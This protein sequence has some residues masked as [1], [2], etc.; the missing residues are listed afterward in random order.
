LPLQDSII[1]SQDFTAAGDSQEAGMKS[2][3][4]LSNFATYVRSYYNFNLLG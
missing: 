4:K 1:G 2:Y 3:E